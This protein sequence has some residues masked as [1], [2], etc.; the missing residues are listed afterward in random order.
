MRAPPDAN[1]IAAVR[2]GR[3]T[4][5]GEHTA[6]LEIR[7]DFVTDLDGHRICDKQIA[8]SLPAVMLRDFEWFRDVGRMNV[9]MPADAT[10]RRYMLLTSLEGQPVFD[11]PLYIFQTQY[12]HIPSQKAIIFLVCPSAAYSVSRCSGVS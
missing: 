12:G 5:R 6:D 11:Q 8:V 2:V 4:G 3:N 1:R 7:V 9:R 10:G